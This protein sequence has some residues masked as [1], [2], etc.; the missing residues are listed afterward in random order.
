MFAFLVVGDTPKNADFQITMVRSHTVL[1][2]YHSALSGSYDS[3][4][5][6]HSYLTLLMDAHRA[7]HAF[8]KVESSSAV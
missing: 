2:D 4:Q 1:V 7:V 3:N 6:E 8:R 5:R